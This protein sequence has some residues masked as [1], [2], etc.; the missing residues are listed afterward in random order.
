[1]F[2]RPRRF[3]VT[4]PQVEAAVRVNGVAIPKTLLD[5]TLKG[6]V[7]RGGQKESAFLF[8]EVREELINLELLAQEA[9]RLGLD[10]SPEAQSQL[11]QVHQQVLSKLAMDHYLRESPVEETDLLTAYHEEI[12]SLGEPGFYQEY[13]LR[14]ITQRSQSEARATI[15]H[16][17]AGGD[18]DKAARER[19]LDGSRDK[20]GLL[21]WII[22]PQVLPPIA[23]VIV[24]LPKGAM[25][26]APIKTPVG[27]NI[28][29]VEDL[30]PYVPPT[31]EE[32]RGK[33]REALIQK[34]RAALLERLHDSAQI[35]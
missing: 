3:E 6:V 13:R 27:W 25:T 9:L 14:L 31:F 19:S 21:E 8:K 5:F 12:E 2:A 4:D 24:H 7:A 34:K 23:D 18:F 35:T 11:Y 32:S 16:I 28:V 17:R 29:R 30:R 26:L 22:L 33:I 1:M 10:K 15:A 20:G